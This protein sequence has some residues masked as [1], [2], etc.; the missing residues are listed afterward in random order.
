MKYCDVQGAIQDLRL[1][2]DL[3]LKAGTKLREAPEL[4]SRVNWPPDTWLNGSQTFLMGG[5]ATV[6]DALVEQLELSQ[7]PTH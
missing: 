7:E 3:I 6:I 4:D 5:L 1:A 2:E